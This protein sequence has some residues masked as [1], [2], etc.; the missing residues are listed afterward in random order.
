MI[1]AFCVNLPQY[2]LMDRWQVPQ[3]QSGISLAAFL[4]EKFGDVS[5]KQIKRVI[6]SGKCLL[7]GKPERFS[8]RLI[9]SGDIVELTISPLS[10]KLPKKSPQESERILYNDDEII[11]FNKPA[12]ILS[13][14][15][16]IVDGLQKLFGQV[17]LLHRLD[18]ETTGILLFARNESIAKA[19]EDLFKKRLIKKKYLAFVNGIPSKSSGIIEN[20]LGKL[21]VY[22]GQTIWGAVPREKGLLAKTSWE[23]KKRGKGASLLIC[24]PETGRTHQIRVHLS[25]LGHPILGDHHYGRSFTCS[26]RPSRLLLHASEISFV[27]PKTKQI[28][29][30][31]SPLPEDFLEAAKQLTNDE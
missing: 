25:G 24:S 20:S 16:Q 17:I 11:A 21:H 14:S 10:S 7:N 19:M 27:H 2:K 23:I 28:I 30:I 13:D 12:G 9:G 4:K 15:Q 22:Q 29:T 31:H 26:Y 18:K 8:S 1:C 3:K 5:A 6:D